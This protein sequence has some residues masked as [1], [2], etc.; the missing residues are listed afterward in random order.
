MPGRSTSRSCESDRSAP[1]KR[2]DDRRSPPRKQSRR[3]SDSRDRRRSP[4]RE[5][6]ARRGGRDRRSRSRSRGRG[7]RGRQ[8]GRDDNFDYGNSGI[9]IQIKSSGF[10]FIKPDTSKD[11]DHNLYFHASGVGGGN[12][13][14]SFHQRDKVMY[15][16]GVDER[17]GQTI[18]KN[19]RFARSEGSSRDRG[20]R[21]RDDSR[22]RGRGRSDSRRNN[23]RRDD[24][25]DRDRRR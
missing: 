6:S 11:D 17:R 22:D 5:P 15:D 2:D 4:S 24:S 7:G 12:S 18:A 1:R 13:F 21:R 10:G 23:G 8:G 3:P 19:V 9:I 20:R 14:D 16:I 25:R